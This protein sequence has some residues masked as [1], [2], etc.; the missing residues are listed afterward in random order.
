MKDLW[1]DFQPRWNPI[2]IGSSRLSAE[3]RLHA[4]NLKLERHT[5]LKVQYHNFM[6]KYKGLDHRDPVNSQEGK[7]HV[8]VYHIIQSSRKYKVVQI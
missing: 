4:T 1:S 3:Q 5:E 6:R 7:K 2:I 8:S